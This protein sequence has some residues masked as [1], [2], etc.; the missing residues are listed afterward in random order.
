M[1]LICF[2]NYHNVQL[3]TVSDL[4]YIGWK[5]NRHE[6]MFMGLAVEEK[7]FLAR[8]ED[9]RNNRLLNCIS[10]AVIDTEYGS[11]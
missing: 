5:G 1:H 8:E 10:E 4:C 2:V 7:C 3:F 6:E 11:S 9:R